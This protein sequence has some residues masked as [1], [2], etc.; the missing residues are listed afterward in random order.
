VEAGVKADLFDRRARVAFNVFNYTVK[1]L[2][3]TAVGGAANANILL[4][5]EK[6]TG[7][8]FEL[9]MQ[10][11]LSDNLLATFGL[12]YNDT[13][14]KDPG[15]AVSV[16]AACTV[17]D[18]RTAGGQAL[19]DGNPLPQAPKTT[20]NFT[21]KYTQPLGNGEMY[22]FTDWVHRSKVNFFLYESVEFTGKAL[23]EGGLRLGYTWAAGKYDAAIF[24]RNITNQM[25]IVGGID[26]NNLT[27][28]INE[29]RTVGVSFR[30]NF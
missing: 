12:G 17:T 23:T 25:R 13:K 26:F 8:G 2:Q 11:L 27:G 3:L 6:A 1:D 29:P 9:D 4:N 30:A 18:P 5:A 28:F 10:A 22:V 21:L 24:G 16:C 19:I 20:A 15:L 7:R 14:L